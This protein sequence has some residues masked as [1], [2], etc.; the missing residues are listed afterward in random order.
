MYIRARACN[1][2]G[3]VESSARAAA[4]PAG[5][6][7]SFSGLPPHEV[8]TQLMKIAT[9]KKCIGRFLSFME[10]RNRKMRL[11]L[12]TFLMFRQKKALQKTVTSLQGLL[13]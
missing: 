11:D 8:N 7:R 5:V 3:L 2:S 13:K 10:Q 12:E 6:L 4:I 1:A 9:A